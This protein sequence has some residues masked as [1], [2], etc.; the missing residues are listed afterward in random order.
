MHLL[1]SQD[2]HALFNSILRKHNVVLPSRPARLYLY[3][4]RPPEHQFRRT[5]LPHR[6]LQGSRRLPGRAPPCLLG[7]CWRWRPPAVQ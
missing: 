2:G 1:I 5:R 3:D 7:P 6:A 4:I